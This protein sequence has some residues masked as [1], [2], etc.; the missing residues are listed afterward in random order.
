MRWYIQNVERVVESIMPV[1]KFPV[2][3][4]WDGSVCDGILPYDAF[5][6]LMGLSRSKFEACVGARNGD[7]SWWWTAFRSSQAGLGFWDRHPW[8]RHKLPSDLSRHLPLMLFDD[9]A[10]V[11]K[12]PLRFVGCGSRCSPRAVTAKR[13]SC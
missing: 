4:T 7:V 5:H 10:A 12:G 9:A 11:A 8:L 6:W 13:V 1:D 3:Q 2:L